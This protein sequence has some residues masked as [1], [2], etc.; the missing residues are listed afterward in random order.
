MASVA[1]NHGP[2]FPL[3]RLHSEDRRIVID[4]AARIEVVGNSLWRRLAAIGGKAGRSL[5]KR[6]PGR[7]QVS[8][9]SVDDLNHPALQLPGVVI[10]VAPLLRRQR[11]HV[12]E[13]AADHGATVGMGAV[14]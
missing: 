9:G 6:Q 11:I 8:Q 5:A 2:E 4:R 1:E 7:L 14:Q 13:R 10:H 12:I 3:G